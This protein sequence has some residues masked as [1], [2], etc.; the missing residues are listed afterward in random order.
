M[1]ILPRLRATEPRETTPIDVESWTE[2]ATESL[3][4]VSLSAV[5]PPANLLRGASVSLAIPLDDAGSISEEEPR[6]VI[7]STPKVHTV[8][9]RREPVRRDSLKRRDALLKGKE[10]SRRRQRWE[11]GVAQLPSGASFHDG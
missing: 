4:N 5:P 11:N 1:A 3:Q 10:G 7:S 2:Q 9:G 6:P 8:Y